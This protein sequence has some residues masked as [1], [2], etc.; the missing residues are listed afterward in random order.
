MSEWIR[1]SR[2]RTRPIRRGFCRPP[3]LPSSRVAS[4]PDVGALRCSEW[5]DRRSSLAWRD[6]E[7]LDSRVEAKEQ[8]F[9]LV[10]MERAGSVGADL[11]IGDW[12]VEPK[13]VRV[14]R[15]GETQRVTP[16]AMA[17]LVCLADA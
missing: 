11:W 12:L 4:R 6:H 9:S 10:G 7:A 8:R 16:R 13:L 14:S 2:P 17:V 3:W 5:V 1:S 15:A